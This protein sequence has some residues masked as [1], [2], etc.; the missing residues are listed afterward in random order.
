MRAP[1]LMY[2][3][4]G[5][6]ALENTDENSGECCLCGSFSPVT[7]P[8]KKAFSSGFSDYSA[9]ANPASE[10]VCAACMWTMTGVPPKTYR[11]W[12]TVYREDLQAGPSPEKAPPCGSR[13]LLTNRGNTHPVIDVLTNPPASG[14]WFV[15]I[16]QSGQKHILVFTEVNQG[17]S[18]SYS[19]RFEGI[20][21]RTSASE[22][23]QV[24]DMALALRAAGFSADDIVTGRPNPAR[25]TPETIPVWKSHAEQLSQTRNG[26]LLE[27]ALYLITKEVIDVRT[28]P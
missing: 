4:A 22:F 23:S 12:S 8:W 10:V 2:R 5:S 21:M 3:D 26:S 16:A 19:V 20:N 11:M 18:P 27:L 17:G 9:L 1:Q 28:K 15:A 7:A 24:F 13:T 14:R 6:P 25:L